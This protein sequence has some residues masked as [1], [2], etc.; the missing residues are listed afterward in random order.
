MIRAAALASGTPVVASD[1]P[2]LRESVR[3]GETGLLVP[4]GD[5]AAM[6]RAM[7]RFAA[8]RA[9]VERFG[10]AGRKF[11]GTFTW[12]RAAE[13]TEAHLATIAGAPARGGRA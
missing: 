1:S 11:A 4:H 6:A 3:D 10:A 8:D 2:G 5:V 7:G 13:E 9:M 12:D